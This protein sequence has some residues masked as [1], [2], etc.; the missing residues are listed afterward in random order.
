MRSHTQDKASGII[1][2]ATDHSSSHTRTSHVLHTAIMRSLKSLA[3][4]TGKGPLPLFDPGR[5]ALPSCPRSSG[6]RSRL[7]HQVIVSRAFNS[8][9]QV[10][11]I[12]YMPTTA[13]LGTDVTDPYARVCARVHACMRACAHRLPLCKCLTPPSHFSVLAGTADSPPSPPTHPHPRGQHGAKRAG[14]QGRVAP[15][16]TPRCTPPM[17]ARACPM[18]VTSATTRPLAAPPTTPTWKV[19]SSMMDWL[20]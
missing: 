3:E 7:S 13:R 15:N 6:R 10:L 17:Q 16:I 9:Q 8:I 18:H 4:L 14:R 2:A 11:F 5:P 19:I 1:C 12:L 20:I